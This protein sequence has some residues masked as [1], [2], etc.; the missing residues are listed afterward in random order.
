[1]P[2]ASVRALCLLALAAWLGWA[3]P[4]HADEWKYD[5]I[6]LKNGHDMTGLLVEETGTIVR[7]EWVRRRSGMSTVVIPVTFKPDEIDHI[8]RLT[9]GERKTLAGRLRSLD[10]TGKRESGRMEGL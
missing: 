1:M 10:P 8:D 5:V 4:A 9:E 3:C 7:F 6:H 2:I